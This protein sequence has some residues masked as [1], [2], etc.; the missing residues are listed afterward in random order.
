MRY[1]SDAAAGEL[2]TTMIFQL[3]SLF[4]ISYLVM[5]LPF[6]LYL[7]VLLS[8]GRFYKDNEIVAAEACGIGLPRIIRSATYFS[9]LMALVV[10]FFSLLV[11]PWAEQKQAEIRDQARAESEFAFISAGRFHEIRNGTGVFYV[12]KFSSDE[13]T[14]FNVFVQLE[15]DGKVDILS[16]PQGLLKYDPESG[17]TYIVLQNGYRYE[18][19]GEGKG[20]RLYSYER[21]SVNIAIEAVISG[22]NK[23]IARQTAYLFGDDSP[24]AVAELNWRIAMPISCVFLTLIAVLLSR[25]NPRQ[26]RFSKL[27]LALLVYI[28][29]EYGLMLAR[30]WLKN[31]VIAPELGMWWVHAIAL[32]FIFALIYRQYG[33][34]LFQRRTT[35]MVESS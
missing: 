22:S 25:T 29:Y 15:Q 18:Y 20:Y 27:L 35:V 8:L 23:I 5:I 21:T 33:G 24:A 19:L 13:K 9:L 31:S 12:E 7:A 17:S 1:M 6:A 10:G 26:G 32:I 30:N 11:A 16:A 4:T 3:L 28:F 2:P 34:Y 14:M